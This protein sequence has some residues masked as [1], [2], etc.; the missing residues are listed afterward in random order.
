MARNHTWTCFGHFTK[1]SIFSVLAHFSVI[2]P[3][4]PFWY[5]YL[6]HLTS[7]RRDLPCFSTKIGRKRTQI[8]WK[9]PENH[10]KWTE[11]DRKTRKNNIGL[12][13]EHFK[14]IRFFSI[15]DP[16]FSDFSSKSIFF[17]PRCSLVASQSVL[18]SVF[19]TQNRW[20]SSQ[21][22]EKLL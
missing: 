16:L 6:S 5:P 15:L 18:F 9:I 10:Q 17:L 7:T 4:S 12:H 22:H 8:K 21:N 11:N 20:N 14:K 1:K 2:F 13:F 3:L 19:R